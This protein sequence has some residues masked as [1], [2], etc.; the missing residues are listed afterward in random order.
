MN[1]W[2]R[3]SVGVDDFI[4]NG[5]RGLMNIYNNSVQNAL[6]FVFPEHGWL[7]WKFQKLPSGYH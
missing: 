6:E 2:N 4:K 1:L 5:G 7:S 3:Y